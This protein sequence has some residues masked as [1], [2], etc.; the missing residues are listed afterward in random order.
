MRV[1]MLFV[2]AL[3]LVL[4]GCDQKSPAPLPTGRFA[5]VHSPH[6]ERDTQLLDTWTGQSWLL[7]EAPGQPDMG[8]ALR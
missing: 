2:A 5:I 3:A 7:V 1:A 6:V 8:I 4:A